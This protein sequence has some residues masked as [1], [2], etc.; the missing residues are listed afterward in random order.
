LT[1]ILIEELH[2][3]LYL[4][5][6][7]CED[8]WKAYSQIQTKSSNDESSNVL[9][10]PR[11]QLLDFLDELTGSIGSDMNED[12]NNRNPEASTFHYLHLVLVS[13]KRMSRLEAALTAI[14]QRLPVELFR[15]VEKCNNEVAARHPGLSLVDTS[16]RGGLSLDLERTNAVVLTDLLDT[17]YARFEAIAEGHRVIDDVVRTITRGTGLTVKSGFKELWKLYQSEVRSLLHDYLATDGDTSFRSGQDTIKNVF[18]KVQRDKNKKMFKLSGLDAK[19]DTYVSSVND[20][21]TLLKTSV[22]GLVSD[23]Q[24][25]SL[26]TSMNLSS[27]NTAL[28]SGTGH[29]LLV[30]ASVFNMG[31]LLP[32]SLEFLQRL[33]EVVP[34]SS[35]IPTG[36]LTN[37]LDDFLVN[38]FLP[39]LDETVVE[40][41]SRVMMEDD[42]FTIDRDW[43][44]VAAKPI[45]LVCNPDMR[46]LISSD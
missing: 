33:K 45:F 28:E 41:A 12:A 19:S 36:T 26:T 10:N 17:L 31:I 13:L 21:E 39:Q 5:S 42:A 22:P 14:E 38:V 44:K 27:V 15:V 29:K 40:A 1:D 23:S 3:H 18:Q 9:R 2:S 16:K 37:F 20:L 46:L 35:D 7:Y 4:K 25:N 11:G 32:P 34:H 43:A 30:E 8:R 6:P 24:R